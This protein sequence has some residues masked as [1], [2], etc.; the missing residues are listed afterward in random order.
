[1]D[2]RRNDVFDDLNQ[3]AKQKRVFSIGQFG[4]SLREKILV[5]V[6]QRSTEIQQI[7]LAV[8]VDEKAAFGRNVDEAETGDDVL[9][10]DQFRQGEKPSTRRK[11]NSM[12]I[13]QFSYSFRSASFSF[14]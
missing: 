4:F 2:Q 10:M 7:R 5:F 13:R 14:S 6:R 11:I 9:M 1:M 12:K 3:I 8:F